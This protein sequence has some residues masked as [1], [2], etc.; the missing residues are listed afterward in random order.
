MNN[1]WYNKIDPEQSGTRNQAALAVGLLSFGLLA[2][3]VVNFRKGAK[4][5]IYYYLRV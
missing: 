4:V 5:R 1:I 2:P 3:L